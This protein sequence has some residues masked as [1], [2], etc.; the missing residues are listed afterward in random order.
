M[1]PDGKINFVQRYTEKMYKH[2]V[3]HGTVHAYIGKL[4]F[5]LENLAVSLSDFEI[6]LM[7]SHII[8]AEEL[9]A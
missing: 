8:E 5:L 9:D 3:E 6:A 2:H 1:T 7:K 4:E